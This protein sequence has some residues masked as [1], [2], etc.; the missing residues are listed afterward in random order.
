MPTRQGPQQAKERPIQAVNSIAACGGE[1]EK[2]KEIKSHLQIYVEQELFKDQKP[3]SLANRRFFPTIKDIRNHFTSFKKRKLEGSP[4]KKPAASQP[5]D[6]VNIDPSANSISRIAN[7]MNEIQAVSFDATSQD[8]LLQTESDLNA[9]LQ[10]LLNSCGRRR[11]EVIPS[12]KPKPRKSKKKRTATEDYDDA[13]PQKLA[14]C[15]SSPHGS[16]PVITINVEC[17]AEDYA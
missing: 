7:L 17:D 16:R 8:A 6:E 14:K 5:L 15:G 1:Y 4:R 11:S 10:N 12:A 2:E 13:V 3:P 9:T